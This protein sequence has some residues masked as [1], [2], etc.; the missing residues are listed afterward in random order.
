M[1]GVEQEECASELAGV[2]DWRRSELLR[3]GYESEYADVLAASLDV[4]LHDAIRLLEQ[5]C[6]PSVAV[7]I[8]L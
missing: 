1:S 7:L 4:D 6:K 3:A 2:R 8:L 5:G